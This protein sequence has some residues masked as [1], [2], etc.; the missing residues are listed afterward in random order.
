MSG[1]VRVAPALSDLV[2]VNVAVKYPHRAARA[3][4]G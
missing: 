2:A 3:D 1:D 4:L